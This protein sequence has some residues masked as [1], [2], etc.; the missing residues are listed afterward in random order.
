MHKH[1]PPALPML[2]LTP[3]PQ[4]YRW[5]LSFPRKRGASL[6]SFMHLL[7]ELVHAKEE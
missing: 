1:E 2:D 4:F 6:S 3:S 5:P 7:R